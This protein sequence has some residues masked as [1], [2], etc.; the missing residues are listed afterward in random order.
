MDRVKRLEPDIHIEVPAMPDRICSGGVE[1][2]EFTTAPD[3]KANLEA[4]LATLGFAKTARHRNCDV[5]LY[6]QGDI[7]ID[8]NTDS[9]GESFGGASYSVHGTNAYAFG[10]KVEDA[11]AAVER[12]AALGAPVLSERAS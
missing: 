7:R 1:F 3:E 4:L 10:I 12:A 5:D 9:S 11:Q 2:V 6:T 8:I